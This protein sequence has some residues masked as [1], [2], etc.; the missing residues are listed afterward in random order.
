[1]ISTWNSEIFSVV[2]SCVAYQP[3]FTC[4]ASLVAKQNKDSSDMVNSVDPRWGGGNFLEGNGCHWMRVVRICFSSYSNWDFWHRNFV[5]H[6][7]VKFS[8]CQH[9]N[10][11]NMLDY[12]L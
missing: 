12:Y 2:P 9:G 6:M 7:K 8:T 4:C 11:V 10:S 1:M 5:S 3:A